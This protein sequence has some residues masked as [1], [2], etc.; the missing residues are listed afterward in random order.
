LQKFK[1][2]PSNKLF[3]TASILFALGILTKVSTVLIAIPILLFIFLKDEKE[4]S[5]SGSKFILFSILTAFIVAISLLFLRNFMSYFLLSLFGLIVGLMIIWYLS[6][7]SNYLT[8]KIQQIIKKLNRDNVTKSISWTILL[9]IIACSY[10]YIYNNYL[11]GTLTN[12]FSIF[13]IGIY[14]KLIQDLISYLTPQVF[15]TAL[16]GIASLFIIKTDKK[17]KTILLA[18]L[19]SSISYWILLS[20]ILFFHDYYQLII[21][22]TFCLFFSYFV[23]SLS[24][25]FK[26]KTSGIIF[27]VLVLLLLLTASFQHS[28]EVISP[29]AKEAKQA[30]EYLSSIMNEN[31]YFISGGTAQILSLYAQRN[32]IQLW[33]LKTDEIANDIKTK[34]FGETLNKLNITYLVTTNQQPEYI[35]I[36]ALLD[37]N[38]QVDPDRDLIIKY[39]LGDKQTTYDSYENRVM[40][41]KLL[42][43]NK[44]FI[45][46]KS[47]GKYNFFRI[48]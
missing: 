30:A 36:V 12:S 23:Y 26:D 9:A 1:E 43:L 35:R 37:K 21:I 14:N 10:Y 38:F 46:V 3:F 19:T 20:R 15:F 27:I 28:R 25:I 2:K 8:S 42:E 18:F 16:L 7:K 22:F 45:L 31:E 48:V 24:K 13:N 29:E 41:V 11:L 4:K 40:L 17:I 33:D 32:H 6:T 44:N 39:V 47:I 34:G 5:K